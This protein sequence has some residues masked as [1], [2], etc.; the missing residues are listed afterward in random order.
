MPKY[1]CSWCVT[2]YQDGTPARLASDPRCAFTPEGIFQ[3]DNWM[4]AGMSVLRNRVDSTLRSEDQSC[5]IFRIPGE[6]LFIILSFYKDRGR[7]EGAWLVDGDEITPL[8][9]DALGEFARRTKP[10]KK[11]PALYGQPGV[12]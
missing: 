11:H 6:P 7:T 5:M 10:A 4:C 3:S 2:A 9:T 8:T 1:Q 12:F